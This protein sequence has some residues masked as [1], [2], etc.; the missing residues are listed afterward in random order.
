LKLT[1]TAQEIGQ[2]AQ[3][4]ADAAAARRLESEVRLAMD[5]KPLLSEESWT[6]GVA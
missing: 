5:Q 3:L 2:L 4:R 6:G 1:F